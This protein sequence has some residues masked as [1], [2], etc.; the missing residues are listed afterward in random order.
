V[1]GVSPVWAAAM[2]LR[3]NTSPV[4]SSCLDTRARPT[5]TERRLEPSSVGAWTCRR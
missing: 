1:Y 3:A 4:A 2:P 5:E